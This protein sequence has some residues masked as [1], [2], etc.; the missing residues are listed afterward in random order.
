MYDTINLWLPTDK[1]GSFNP[2]KTIQQLSNITE[3]I[4]DDGQ[5]YASGYLK[6]YKVSIFKRKSCKVFLA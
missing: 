6:N 4:R 2:S 1:V 5:I 3:H